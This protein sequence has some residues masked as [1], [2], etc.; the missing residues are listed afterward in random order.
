ML[1][2]QTANET[3]LSNL[4][5]TLPDIRPVV[6]K[7]YEP[8]KPPMGQDAQWVAGAN[9]YWAIRDLN[10]DLRDIVFGPESSARTAA[11]SLLYNRPRA[12]PME[13]G[14][15]QN[16]VVT[17]LNYA[18]RNGAQRFYWTPAEVQVDRYFGKFTAKGDNVAL[19]WEPASWTDAEEGNS[20][21]LYWRVFQPGK[22]EGSHVSAA[23]D[24]AGGLPGAIAR[25][26]FEHPEGGELTGNQMREL[27]IPGFRAFY[28]DKIG[29]VLARLGKKYDADMGT[30]TLPPLRTV[31]YE[32]RDARYDDGRFIELWKVEQRPGQDPV[33]TKHDTLFF[34]YADRS[35]DFEP[36]TPDEW[37]QEIASAEKRAENLTASVKQGK[38]TKLYYMDLTDEMKRDLLGPHQM[39]Y[40]QETRP[41]LRT[42]IDARTNFPDADFWIVRRGTREAVGKPTR[43]F[44]PEHIGI[45]VT[46]TDKLDPGYLFYALE[47]VKMQGYY[48]PR[49]TTRLQGIRVED[50][51]NVPIRV[52]GDEAPLRQPAKG[53]ISFDDEGRA[54]VEFYRSRDFSTGIHE[55]GHV[56]TRQLTKD[57][58]QIVAQEFNQLYG[59]NVQLDEAGHFIGPEEKVTIL[60]QTYASHRM[61]AE[62]MFARSLERYF[63]DGIA[64]TPRLAGIFEFIKR[65]MMSVYKTVAGSLIDLEITPALRKV[66]DDLW[67]ANP[68]AVDDILR[69]F[70]LTRVEAEAPVPDQ[71]PAPPRA[72]RLPGRPA[73]PPQE[74][75]GGMTADGRL[76]TKT[77][78]EIPLPRAR[79][80]RQGLLKMDAWLH[81]QA[82]AEL[83]SRTVLVNDQ[84]AVVRRVRPPTTDE[85]QL[86]M[87]RRMDPKRL[88]PSDRDTLNYILFGVEEVRFDRPAPRQPGV[89]E[90]VEP[91]TPAPVEAAPPVMD[92][93]P[94]G[95]TVTGSGPDPNRTFEFRYRVMPLS[96]AVISTLPTGEV[97]PAYP[98]ELLQP[99]DRSR[100]A[101]VMQM[102]EIGEGLNLDLLLSYNRRID[103]GTPIIGP[104]GIM[105]SGN[106]RTA[107][108]MW[109]RDNAPTRWTAYHDKLVAA[110]ESFGLTREQVEAIKDPI[111]VRERLSDVDR[112]EFV[113]LANASSSLAMSAAETARADA[114]R[115]TPEALARFTVGENETV[116]QALNASRNSEFTRRFLQHVPPTDRA[117]MLEADGSIARKGIERI[118]MAMLVATYPG[119]KGML[120]ARTLFESTDTNVRNLGAGI[121]GSLGKMSQMETAIARGMAPEELSLAQDVPYAVMRISGLRKDGMT[122]EDY[123]MQAEAFTEAETP[124]Q[125]RMVLDLWQVSQAPKKIRT[126]LNGYAEKVLA[127]PDIRQDTGLV[128]QDIP[129]KE[130]LWQQA[131]DGAQERM[132]QIPNEQAQL[133]GMDHV[134]VGLPMSAQLAQGWENMRPLV[135]R[136]RQRMSQ[137]DAMPKQLSIDDARARL[138]PEEQNEVKQWVVRT[139][140]NMA[141]NKLATMRYSE[142]ERD[143]TLLNYN[144]TRGFDNVAIAVW[145]YEFWPTRTFAHWA[146]RAVDKPWL[147]ATYLKL[148]QAQSRNQAP[149]GFPDRLRGKV[150]IPLPWLPDWMGGAV[151]VDPW[152]SWFPP[153]MFAGQTE[154][155]L[156]QRGEVTQKAE[157]LLQQKAQAG[158]ISRSAAMEAMSTHSGDTWTDAVAEAKIATESQMMDPSDLIGTYLSYS[159]PVEWARQ[160][161]RGTPERIGPMPA[162]RTVRDVSALLGANGGR[163]WNIEAPVRRAL[164]MPEGDQFEEY[165]EDRMLATM[166]AEG[167][168]DIEEL[169]QAGITRSGPVFQE[170]QRR[171]EEIRLAGGF[172][173]P[174]FYAGFPGDLIP[175][176]EAE[177]RALAGKWQRALWLY[178]MGD[179]SAINTFLDEYPEYEL[180][181]QSFDDPEERLRSFLIDQIWTDYRELGSGNKELISQQLGRDFEESFL[182]KETRNTDAIPLPLLAQWAKALGGQAPVS[183][184]VPQS[185]VTLP[186][187]DL[188]LLTPEQD[189]EITTYRETRDAKFPNWYALGQR[190]YSLPPG[191]QRRRFI[192]QFPEYA[193]YTAWNRRYKKDHPTVQWFGQHFD[194]EAGGNVLGSVGMSEI[195]SNPIL[196]GQ[197]FGYR[198]ANAPLT[199]GALEEL[200]RVWEEN[201]SPGQ[202]FQD[203]L[204]AVSGVAQ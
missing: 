21:T 75:I 190:Y 144:A 195:M 146:M 73:A 140:G 82:I 66:M 185:G 193:A 142:A 188:N 183:P 95:A 191:A 64:P 84:G 134:P 176:G 98:A 35:P 102:Q 106:G 58:R 180:R 78:R 71:A 79:A 55:H 83:E 2:Q 127:I 145:P 51:L 154:Y 125:R 76:L 25:Y 87:V 179:D 45:K 178:R 100:A 172:L 28:D 6:D 23:Q 149:P 96:E 59:I 133:P 97:N 165:R 107:G 117:A 27:E 85:F 14:Y 137:P 77:G 110:A 60:G 192:E 169:K 182:D 121:L 10:G 89:A 41:T 155:M 194:I 152:R 147:I 150:R 120:L 129:P 53:A 74:A 198:E 67:E 173:N 138:T 92:A 130:E 116:E 52:P 143:F 17:A 181:L 135:D 204:A 34:E 118:V 196:S 159:M 48:E 30:E 86:D 170:A 200:M 186:P 9:N 81:A 132:F 104:D 90:V 141:G 4:L 105:E 189:Q 119:E 44:N 33:E 175:E 61:A 167:G 93:Y 128:T 166:A 126:Y 24:L 113:Q 31:R 199:A 18:M 5:D 22:R 101:S 1:D 39:M 32:V 114:A 37:A 80:T 156:Q 50:V 201:G 20:G 38:P 112:V 12:M 11:T 157:E 131:K 57:Q 42:M 203:W 115:M 99:R 13:D 46:A 19:A 65:A 8:F 72:P 40:Q 36:V 124:F 70:D 168:W 136:L 122:L 15:V 177:Q 139:K 91:P 63:Y 162:T 184:Q 171:V 49:G 94:G 153:A 160:F 108:L 148:M 88:S 47:F 26:I 164:K 158:L 29:G 187:P 43:E 123:R 109:A 62:E 7:M 161:A 103:D 68:K 3:M 56:W 163:G 69:D 174:L 197:L 111:L 16:G 151:W 202:S 54:L